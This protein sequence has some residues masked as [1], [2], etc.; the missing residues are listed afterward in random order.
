MPSE[1]IILGNC[2]TG[3][4][5]CIQITDSTRFQSISQF[6]MKLD[7]DL[8]ING[9]KYKIPSKNKLNRCWWHIALV[10][11]WTM[12]LAKI[13]SAVHIATLLNLHAKIVT[14]IKSSKNVI[15]IAANKFFVGKLS[16]QI[17]TKNL[18]K[19]GDQIHVFWNLFLM[20]PCIYFNKP[21]N[22]KS[23]I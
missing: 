1:S 8:K 18:T 16:L 20:G 11:G 12:Y 15:N 2:P 7:F 23:I 19:A 13:A 21:H 10:G 5:N 9:R 4:F 14:N 22:W 3:I 6:T 17:P